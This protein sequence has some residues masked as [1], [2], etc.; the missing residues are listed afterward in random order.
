LF[1]PAQNAPQIS[2]LMGNDHEQKQGQ[3]QEREHEQRRECEHVRHNAGASRYELALPGAG[4]LAI[5]DYT[6]EPARPEPP[7]AAPGNREHARMVFTHTYVPPSMRGKGAAEK[8]AR[9]ALADA[10]ANGRR[11]VP[12]CSYVAKFIERHRAEYADLLAR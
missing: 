2:R 4:E 11:V 1:A 12:E 8:L 5:M 6:L 10:R 3:Q 7:G 9:A